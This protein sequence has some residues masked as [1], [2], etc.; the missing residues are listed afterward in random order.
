VGEPIGR[1]IV[2]VDGT[3]A[4]VQAAEWATALA[5]ATGKS[6]DLVT[7]W[8][9]A[10]RL[11]VAPMAMGP[12]VDGMSVLVADEQLAAARST[13][14]RATADR[15]ARIVGAERRNVPLRTWALHGP[16]AEVLTDLAGP[17]DLLVVGPTGHRAVVGA[18]LGS[19]ASTLICTARC[20]V[21]VVRASVDD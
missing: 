4:S 9:V 13:E 17:G 15:V 6:V 19:V 16:P 21:V 8:D 14:A 3:P 18:L 1:I 11:S 20:P 12:A 10:S 7:A 5:A 2:G